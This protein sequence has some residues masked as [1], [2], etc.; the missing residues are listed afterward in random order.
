[1][2]RD[3]KAKIPG[4]ENFTY[5]EF[6][7]SATAVRNGIENIP[8]E[9]QWKKV[10][11][12]ARKVLQPVRN[13]FGRLRITSGFRSVALCIKIG[14]SPSSNHAKGEAADIEP[15]DSSISLLDIVRWIYK[16][17]EFRTI[18]LEYAPDGWVHVDYREGGNLKKLKLKDEKHNYKDVTLEYLEHLYG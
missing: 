9:E 8:T 11:T 15:Y 5:G 18:I 7:K 6:V 16:N 12:L 2:S 10:E 4:A 14:S 1:M 13:R 3:L 17:L